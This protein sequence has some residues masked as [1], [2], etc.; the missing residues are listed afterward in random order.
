MEQDLT[1]CDWWRKPHPIQFETLIGLDLISLD[2][3][4]LS[5]NS[6]PTELRTIKYKQEKWNLIKE[7]ML[8]L[9]KESPTFYKNHTWHGFQ[10]LQ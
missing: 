4:L 1:L 5:R 6:L 7:Q 2:L 9:H 10:H 8:L 3:F